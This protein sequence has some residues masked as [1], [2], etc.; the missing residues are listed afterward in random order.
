VARILLGLGGTG[1][2]DDYGVVR[3]PISQPTTF[4]LV[5]VSRPPTPGIEV[6]VAD[7]RP[8][9]LWHKKRR[10]MPGLVA[11]R[12]EEISNGRRQATEFVVKAEGVH[13]D[14]RLIR[15][16]APASR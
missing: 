3:L 15:L 7:M 1:G 13:V 11:R 8:D 10:T 14:V 16:S 6:P 4:E 5:S 2:E 9:F 12:L